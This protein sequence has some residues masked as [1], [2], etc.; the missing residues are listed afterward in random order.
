MRLPKLFKQDSYKTLEII[1]TTA[2]CR[3][4]KTELKEIGKYRLVALR[5][6]EY[7]TEEEKQELSKSRKQKQKLREIL[8]EKDYTFVVWEENGRL[9]L[10]IILIYIPAVHGVK[11]L[12][13]TEES[14]TSYISQRRAGKVNHYEFTT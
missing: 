8:K 13:W 14:L 3:G 12:P 10:E 9:D 2:E 1:G 5:C 7:L 11:I 4:L 6:R